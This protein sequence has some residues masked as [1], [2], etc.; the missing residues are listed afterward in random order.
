MN[1]SIHYLAF[2]R[3]PAH[4][5]AAV[6]IRAF[7]SALAEHFGPVRLTTVA[8]TDGTPISATADGQLTSNSHAANESCESLVHRGISVEGRNLIERVQAFR[9]EILRSWQ[10][11]D[12]VHFRSIFEGY[13]LAKDKFRFCEKIVYEVNGLPS[14][15]LK[16]HYP[17][18]AEDADFLRKLRHQ[19][20]ACLDAADVILTV[21]PTN[22]EYLVSDRQ[23][24]ADKIHV[25]PNGVDTDL[26]TYRSWEPPEN[27]LR[28]LYV[29]TLSPWQGLRVAIEAVAMYRRDFPVSLTIIGEGRAT[30]KRQ[31]HELIDKLDLEEHVHVHPATSQAY[32]A[33]EYARHH[34]AVAPLMAND[35]NRLQGCCPLKVLEAMA[36]GTPLIA[37]DLQVVRVLARDGQ[38]A[39][40]VRPG[41]AK[42][43]KDALLRVRNDPGLCTRITA[44]ARRRVKTQFTWQIA[45]Q[46]LVDVYREV[47]R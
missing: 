23:I 45:Q 44:A 11:V 46:R 19:E 38:E 28:V 21:S 8:G 47:V 43:I 32:L 42:A 37:S 1:T 25:I 12:V 35:R 17:N 16:Y 5:G 3:Y 26:F 10:P 9:R 27:D 2:D 30:Q 24:S 4:K 18:V 13:P 34:C 36:C 41:S 40:L 39:I 6:H 31:L 29:G 20:Q 15:E 22:A 14:I 33:K 7:V